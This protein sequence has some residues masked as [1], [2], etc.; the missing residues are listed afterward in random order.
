MKGRLIGR[1]ARNIRSFEAATGTTLVIDETPDSV[2]VSSFNPVRR[3]AAKIALEALI[4]DGRI[5]PASIE[6]AAESAKK[7][8]EQH[9]YDIGSK[10]SPFR[11]AP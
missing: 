9:V 1:E 11:R 7:N 8:M 6:H 10:G 5:N 4:A 3:E 2:S